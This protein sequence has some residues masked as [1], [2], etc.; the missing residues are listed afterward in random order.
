MRYKGNKTRLSKH[1]IPIIESYAFDNYI[2]PF[3]GNCGIIQNVKCKN[4][5]AND[6]NKYIVA[7]ME[8][9]R[10]GWVPPEN[11]SE[12]Y[13]KHIKN[14]KDKYPECLVGFVGFGCSFGGIFFRCYARCKNNINYA[15]QSQIS[16]LKVKHR[17]QG[18][19]FSNK[20]YDELIIPY[21]SLIYCDPPYSNTEGYS[22]AFDNDKF[23]DWAR[24][25]S[26]RNI[27]LVSEY[28]APEDFECIWSKPVTCVLNKSG[29][30]NK[31]EK[32]F[33]LKGE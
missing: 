29:K 8:A 11:I 17:L 13:Y 28:T 23:W 21:N 2:E 19:Q 18:I 33:K 1:I 3:C 6:Y 4:R 10:D 7:L 14:N 27:V 31:I 26:E 20:S 22:N 25:E 24:K 5:L 9:I 12:E 32:L 30:V 15:R 16:L